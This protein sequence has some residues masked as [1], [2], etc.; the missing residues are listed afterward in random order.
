LGAL[1]GAL[2]GQGYALIGPTVRDGAIV[3]AEIDGV[4]S[5]PRGWTDEQE[6][7]RYR[8]R[9][10][11]DD[12][13]FGFV[14][15]PR[16]FKRWF[17]PPR[18]KLFQAERDGD[19]GFHVSEEPEAPRRLALIGA[20]SCELAAMRIHDRVLRDGPVADPDYVRRRADVFT[21]AVQCAEAGGTCFCTSM[22]TGP[23]AEGGFDL[24]LT[25]LIDDAGH[26]FVVEVGSDRGAAVMRDV[27]HEAASEELV[28]RARAQ[29]DRCA[30]GMGRTME[31]AGL[32]DLLLRNLEHPRWDH[33]ADRCLSCANC[34]MV[35]PTCFCSEVE[36][37]TDLTGQRAERTRHWDSCFT[38]QHSHLHAGS[39]RAS[40]RARYRQWLTHK[41]ATWHDQFGSSGCVGCGR[42][43]TWCPVGIDIT[44]EVRAIRA[45]DG[46]GVA[47][48]EEGTA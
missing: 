1:L 32:R 13:Y 9:R 40:T 41:L 5:L 27:P 30:Q 23:R 16:S 21:V 7:G 26:R 12:A 38:M 37:H 39:V 25:E 11:S 18:L 6:A 43:V 46:G 3:Y 17:F 48:A 29:S 4:Q 35:C 45:T 34:T 33:V 2:A 8:L 42:C 14:V 10:R 24:A 19:G 44:E 15:G 22:Q 36:D 47:G 28:G 20:R 31:T